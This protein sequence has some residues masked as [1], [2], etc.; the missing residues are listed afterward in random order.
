[1]VESDEE[2]KL[3]MLK[4]LLEPC[5]YIAQ[6]PGPQIPIKLIKAFDGWL[7][8]P[9]EKLTIIEDVIEML[10]SASLLIDD[11]E[12]SS[13]LRSGVPVAHHIY[14][15]PLTMNAAN[16]TYFLAM[17]K[18]LTLDH[19]QVAEIFVGKS[20]LQLIPIEPNT[21]MFRTND[22]IS[23]WSRN[24]NLVARKF[25]FTLRRR[26]SSDGLSKIWKFIPFGCSS[27]ATFPS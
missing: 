17:Q 3:A 19:P 20:L 16:Y 25:R 27:H 2:S 7:H 12:D 21:S 23:S 26:I 18:A 13:K 11:I 4:I 15:T 14:G 6:L 1:M 10:H 22:S 24:R 5:Q 9:E 8:I